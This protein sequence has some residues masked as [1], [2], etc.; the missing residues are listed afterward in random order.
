MNLNMAFRRLPHLAWLL[1]VWIALWGNVS[2]ANLVSGA[3][4]V[5]VFAWAFTEVGPLP[6]SRMNPI[7]VLMLLGWFAQHLVIS[8]LEVARL[9]L[10][11]ADVRPAI[12]AVP[13]QGVS[14]AVVTL[15]ADIITLTPGSMTVDVRSDGE[16]A[17]LY[18]HVVDLEDEDT[19]RADLN[20]LQRLAM[21][22]FG[23]RGAAEHAQETG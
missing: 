2:V 23:S 18:V 7:Y 6:A 17:V 14:D 8:T 16:D 1:A 21:L 19:V 13:M 10:R 11:S 22:A 15:V 20:E 5:G 3:I 12:I 4:V 9:V